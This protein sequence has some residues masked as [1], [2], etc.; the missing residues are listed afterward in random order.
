MK[1]I[2]MTG[3][4]TGGHVTPNLALIP[5]LQADGWEIHYIGGANSA[6]QELISRVPGVTFYTVA[7]GKL[8]RYFDLKNFSDPFRVIKGVAQAARII[9]KIKPD[10]VFSKGGFVSVPVVYG[11]KLNGV[12]VVT[13]ESDLTPGLA[14][15][16]C[17]PFASVQCCTFP[18]AVKYSKGKGIYTG[19]P[20]RPEV[21]QGSREAGRRRFGFDGNLPVLMVV[22]G[23]SGAQ[24]INDCV[25]ACL[26]EL[27]G[28]FQ[29]LH[30]CGKGNHAPELE[31]TA[32]YVQCEFLNEEMA[33]AYACADVLLSRAG[34][35]SLC[36]ILA[37]RKPA[38][39]IP[40]P[41]TASR[42][43]QI[44]N[45]QSFASRGLSR[46]LAQADMTPETLPSAIVEVY[47]DRGALY[48]AMSAETTTDGVDNV[49]HQIYKYAK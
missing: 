28:A 31:G 3:G 16:L 6:E 22:G 18:E 40:Y 46:V 8:R 24:A 38:L 48:E 35:N 34:S 43:D 49:L 13:H 39:L 47:R 33:D 1:K 14:N 37:L 10:V 20:I 21:L 5:R 41:S 19:T 27:T 44:L 32:N 2:V 36:E 25:R 29:V 45:A 23:S 11:A 42:G 9:R 30:L 7:V 26:P 12:P 17:L 4:G 15:K